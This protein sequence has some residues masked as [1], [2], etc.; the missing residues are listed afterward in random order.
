MTTDLMRTYFQRI[1]E[2][3]RAYLEGKKAGKELKQAVKIFLSHIVEFF[4][5]TLINVFAIVK[6]YNFLILGL[7]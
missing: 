6:Y 4:T 1:D 3:E 2:Y 5:S 7:F